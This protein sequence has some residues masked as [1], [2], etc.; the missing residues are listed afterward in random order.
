MYP[1]KKWSSCKQAGDWTHFMWAVWYCTTH[2]NQNWKREDS[3]RTWNQRSRFKCKWSWL[4]C[5]CS[6]SWLKCEMMIQVWAQ[7]EDYDIMI[8]VW[9]L[10][11]EITIEV[12]AQ[13]ED[14]DIMNQVSIEKG[15]RNSSVSIDDCQGWCK[16]WLNCDSL[17][18]FSSTFPWSWKR[19]KAKNTT[20]KIET[21][22]CR[23]QNV[24]MNMKL[25]SH[26]RRGADLQAFV[27][28]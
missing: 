17:L 12:R 15:D 18:Q 10:N 19:R 26:H 13:E 8:Q 24:Q 20:K 28:G 25:S 5:T 7:E 2:L 27:F 9:A 11:E 16:F 14:H 22:V 21:Y 6:K 1:W 23:Q 3:S 4:K